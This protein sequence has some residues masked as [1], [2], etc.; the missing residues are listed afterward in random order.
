MNSLELSDATVDWTP[1]VAAEHAAGA[2][3]TA[4]GR[5]AE[6]ANTPPETRKYGG[7]WVTEFRVWGP[8]ASDVD[9][10]HLLAAAQTDSHIH[11]VHV[12][13]RGTVESPFA[14]ADSAA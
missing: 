14:A 3:L 7:L 9:A 10:L 2:I 5:P 13:H 6:L 1:R 12:V 11:V 8:G 4:P